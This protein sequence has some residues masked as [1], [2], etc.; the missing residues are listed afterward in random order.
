VTNEQYKAKTLT[1]LDPTSPA[2]GGLAPWTRLRWSPFGAVMRAQDTVPATS[3][4]TVAA[5]SLSGATDW[6]QQP[7]TVDPGVAAPTGHVYP[8]D[9]TWRT[10]GTYQAHV[11]PGCELRAQVLYCPA[12]LTQF[13]TGGGVNFASAGAWAE[14]R[15]R[16][17]WTNGASTDGPNDHACTMEGSNKG[18]YGG[19]ENSG[20]GQN[21]NDLREKQIVNIRPAEYLTDPTVA[22]AFSEWSDVLLQIQVRGGARVVAVRVY[23]VPRAHVTLHSNAGLTSVHAM[24]PSLAPQTSF[25]QT[26]A[27]DGTTYEEHRFGSVRTLQVAERQSERLGPRPFCFSTWNESTHDTLTDT[28]VDPL[29]TASSSLVDLFNSSITAYDDNNPGWII[30]GS[31]AQLHRLCDARL[32]ARGRFAVIP[33]RVR[34]D[35]SRS[36]G[37]GTVRVQSGPYEWVDVS[38]TGAR[39]WYEAVGY[40]RSQVFADHNSAS[41]QVFGRCSGGGTLSLYGV[42]VDFGQWAS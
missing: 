37:T 40:L 9:T 5:W 39:D 1:G 32:I 41:C 7:G 42:S 24:P 3:R 34:V 33:V 23:E 22:V 8:T 14:L 15:V 2:I 20:A 4:R 13:D 38:I 21:W 27:T 12:G 10:L 18:D 28:D 25:P 17:T 16:A 30:D 36:A 31:N 11:T 6:A 19:L 29:T 35:A 26:K